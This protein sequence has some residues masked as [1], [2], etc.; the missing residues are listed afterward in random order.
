MRVQHGPAVVDRVAV[1]AHVLEEV[2]ITDRDVAA[3]VRSVVAGLLGARQ[4]TDPGD[5][6][7]TGPSHGQLAIDRMLLLW[8]DY[9]RW[10]DPPA[11]FQQGEGLVL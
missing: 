9:Y 5:A 3:Q 8:D 11:R 10:P 4:P 1:D 7:Q 2:G 6:V